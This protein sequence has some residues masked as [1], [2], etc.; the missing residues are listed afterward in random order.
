MKAKMVTASEGLCPPDSLLPEILV[1]TL[2][3]LPSHQLLPLSLSVKEEE[4]QITQK[5]R[6]RFTITIMSSYIH[7]RIVLCCPPQALTYTC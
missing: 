3:S 5:L 2:V 1:Y 4:I 6:S 7:K